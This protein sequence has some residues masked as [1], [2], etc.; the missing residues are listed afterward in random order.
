MSLPRSPVRA[1]AVDDRPT[2]SNLRFVPPAGESC[3]R[4]RTFSAM[5]SGFGIEDIVFPG[6]HDR[7]QSERSDVASICGVNG[8]DSGGT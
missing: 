5:A 4:H 8:S 3:S 7:I 1:A 6:I 2:T